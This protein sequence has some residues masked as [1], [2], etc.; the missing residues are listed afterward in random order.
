[1]TVSEGKRIAVFS[2]TPLFPDFAMGGGQVQLKKVALHLGE[3]GHRLTIL[4]T[5]H[6]E[7]TEPFSWHEKVHIKP[8]LRF[9]QPY[10]EPYFTPLYNIANAM[11]AVGDAIVEADIHYS[12]DGGLIFPYVYK[13]KP[14]IFSMRSIIYP[15]TLQSALLFQGDEWILPSEHT[16][17]SYAA[18]VSQFCPEVET[19]MHAIHNGFDWQKYRYTEPDAIFDVIPKEIA[20]CPVLL[21]PHR[22]DLNKGIYEVVKVARRLVYDYGWTDLRVLVPRGLDAE[23][24]PG[25]RAYY[26]Q[27]QQE[28]G[29]T[30]LTDSF[31]F[32]DW[33]N[34]DL[35]A[36]YYSIADVTMCIGNCVETFGNTPFESLGCGTPAILSRVST[37]RDLFSDEHV[38]RVDYGDIDGAAEYAHNILREKRRTSPATLHYLKREFSLEKM[39]TRYADVIL[40]AEKKPPLT[41]RLPKLS[42]STMYRKAPWCY[43]SE[44]FGIYHDFRASYNKDGPLVSTLRANP[45]GFAGDCV[46]PATLQD[47]L[48]KGYVVPLVNA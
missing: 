31:Y 35:I 23:T 13:D 42:K 22:P 20:A 25:T 3:L 14:T 38:D 24:A 1:M 37:Y 43:L 15:E 30:R 33:I 5:R 12:H 48:D 27:L 2:M 19:R 16:R 4:S 9:K 36:E 34:E 8:I 45:D 6:E 46:D 47:W 10:P 39:V 11:R 28:I 29:S 41:Y 40:N 21:F 32:H 26:E 18:A 44:R 7:S 17:A